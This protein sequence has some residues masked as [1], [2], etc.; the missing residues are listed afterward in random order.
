MGMC[1]VR[2]SQTHVVLER[3]PLGISGVNIKTRAH[4]LLGMNVVSH[5]YGELYYSMSNYS[6][7]KLEVVKSYKGIFQERFSL[8]IQTIIV[9]LVT[10]KW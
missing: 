8:C 5:C 7:M 4:D 2:P 6:S 1:Y 3:D 9:P 10:C